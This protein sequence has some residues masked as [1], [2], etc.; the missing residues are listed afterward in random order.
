MRIIKPY[1]RSS[2]EFNG[3]DRLT[4]KLRRNPTYKTPVEIG[5]FAK[6]HPELVIA[7]W[8]SAI[9]KIAAKPYGN[10]KPTPE[11]RE[12]RQRL[13]KAVFRALTEKKLIDLSE[14]RKNEE[15]ALDKVWWSKI[16]PYGKG[17][18]EKTSGQAEGR[19]YKRFVGNT[20]VSKADAAT[21]AERIYDHLHK[22]EYRIHEPRPQKRDGRI[23]A[24]AASIRNNTLRPPPAVDFVSPRW[25][26]E[27]KHAYES[28][29][30]VAAEIAHEADEI[31]KGNRR[32]SVRTAA[33]VLFGQYGR[34]FTD[35]NGNALSIQDA[36]KEFP[37][38]FA[39]H[40][41]IKD[42]YTRLL[43]RHK[44]D[45]HKK[46]FIAGVLPKDM[47]ALFGLIASKSDNRNLNALVRLGK[48][49]HYAA[50]PQ[51]N[52]DA[53]CNVIDNWPG[54][55]THSP[56]WTSDGQAKIKRNEAFVRVWRHTIA[57][58]AQTLKD[59]A[60]PEG[61]IDSDILSSKSDQAIDEKF[62]VTAYCE[63][64]RT[65]FGDQ[66]H[67]FKGEND[68]FRRSILKLTRKWL[69]ALRNSSFHF[70]GRGGFVNAL[71]QEL[72]DTEGD[73]VTAMR[74]LLKRD[75]QE[76]RDRMIETLRAAH[77]EHYYDQGRLDT[78]T[79]AV[80]GV[81]PSQS[82]M[83]RFRRILDRAEKAW[84]RKP[85]IL[86][87]PPPGK[88]DVLEQHPDRLCRYVVTKMLYE[89]A[90]PAWLEEQS[91]ETLNR[92]IERA[93]ERTTQAAQ[94]INEDEM[95]VAK[96]AGLILL[97]DRASDSTVTG[98]PQS[99][100]SRRSM[101]QERI[102]HFFDRLSA[103]TATEMRVQRGYDSDADK[104]REQAKY[105]DDLRCDVVGQAFETFL[106][107]PRL[108]WVLDEL[109]DTR[110]EKE[111]GNLDATP[112]TESDLSRHLTEDWQAVLYF[113][114]HLVPVDAVGRLQHQLRKWTVLEGRPSDDVQAVQRLF[115]LYLDMHDAKFKGGAGM[116][117]AEALKELFTP[118]TVF[119]QACPGQ[120]GEDTGRYVPW[121]GL[122]EILRFGSLRPLMP[123]FKQHR[124]TAEDLKKVTVTETSKNGEENVSP[125]ANRQ[126]KRE[127][128][129]AKWVKQKR[130]F[131]DRDRTDY[132]K[133]LAA[134]VSHRHLA[135]HVRLNNHARLYGLLM[136]VLGRLADY[137]GLW[138]RDL[139]FTTLALTSLQN[140]HPRDIF[141][142]DGRK[143]LNNG[144]I[145]NA[146]RALENSQDIEKR[147]IFCRM[148][149]SFGKDFLMDGEQGKGAA[150]IR[151]DLLHFNMLRDPDTPL[152]LTDSVNRTRQLMAYD[153]KLKNAV[154]QS[155]KEMLAREGFDLTWTMKDHR[156]ERAKVKVRQAVHLKEKKIK[157]N[158]HGTQFVKMVASL[159]NGE[160]EP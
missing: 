156:L 141:N 98:T 45:P 39:L 133:A 18:D 31:E 158:L 71:T 57:L 59:W 86:R 80:V 1:G 52:E 38:L 53:P 103:A 13:G 30:D 60:D 23:A 149:Q 81:E 137:A 110:P 47:A 17:I 28:A 36:S 121:R 101:A 88:R 84:K 146:L 15:P 74:N 112:Q 104:A 89:R 78:L 129:H 134:V 33:E 8:I 54:D 99:S 37:G 127:E 143:A 118:E 128:L 117:G 12:F 56:Y 90:F 63:K 61:S 135:A 70:V 151:N 116:A 68:D 93:A 152:D 35:G 69:A 42:T 43:K 16:H 72:A 142:K 9:D 126:R 83:P 119:Y 108:A 5:K 94:K 79:A 102:A 159:F 114:I 29:G 25:T 138:E 155:I 34:L 44:K 73:R 41:A 120:P 27:D 50:A 51:G 46:R 21:I 10:K 157:E 115:G 147:T 67:L 49:I 131:S 66:S 130:K 124:I 144:R 96:A 139:Y 32:V 140:K 97:D 64:I 111:L 154:S 122:R 95:A 4:R 91:A 55:V 65:L 48:V 153:R 85:Y 113:L 125:L 132:C 75:T 11:Q 100:L 2:T 14:S 24:R 150:S 62:N 82:P 148:Q 123:I 26:D 40:T 107:E 160:Q 76:L 92:W 22:H 106:N 20:D 109:Q 145:V 58:A 3:K 87:L 6:T 136:Q 77:V 105:I 7:Q 19:W